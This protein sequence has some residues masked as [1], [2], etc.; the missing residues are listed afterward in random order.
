MPFLQQLRLRS[1][2]RDHLHVIRV[3]QAHFML[4]TLLKSKIRKFHLNASISFYLALTFTKFTLNYWDRI[5]Q[6][7]TVL[8]NGSFILETLFMTLKRSLIF[9]TFI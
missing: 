3:N 4:V 9:V 8:V 2:S 7:L 1:N 6:Y 5:R